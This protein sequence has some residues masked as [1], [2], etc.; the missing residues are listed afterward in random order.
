MVCSCR[1]CFSHYFSR[2]KNIILVRNLL[3][4][5]FIFSFYLVFQPFDAIILIIED[6]LPLNKFNKNS[7]SF[8]LM[9]SFLSYAQSHFNRLV[10][11]FRWHFN[12]YQRIYWNSASYFSYYYYYYYHPVIENGIIITLTKKKEK[13]APIF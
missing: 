12:F 6:F 5:Y 1:N 9:L 3:V 2:G 13:N 10:F 4:F 8:F 7:I 11:L